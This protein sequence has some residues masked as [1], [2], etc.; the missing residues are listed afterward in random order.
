MTRL[1]AGLF[2]IL[3]TPAALQ[4][5]NDSTD[6]STWTPV[7]IAGHQKAPEFADITA[8]INSKPLTMAKLK[9]KVVVVHFLTF[10]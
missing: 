3:A 4:A 9:G 2:F 5:G 8:W 10:G 7:K 6:P 1:L